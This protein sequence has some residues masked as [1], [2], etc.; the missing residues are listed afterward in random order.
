M[1]KLIK[2]SILKSIVLAFVLSI[3]PGMSHLMAQIDL[4]LIGTWSGIVQQ[5]GFPDYSTVMTIDTLVIG[6]ASGETDY[7]TL[8][9][10]GAN[11]FLSNTDS[12]HVFSE[13]TN[14]GICS[15]GR[16]EIFKLAEDTIMFNWYY[17]GGS[18][19]EASGILTRL[20]TG[21]EDP[22]AVYPNGVQISEIYPNPFT[23]QTSFDLEVDQLENISITVYNSLGSKMQTIYKGEILPGQKHTF[24]IQGSEMP[25]GCYILQIIGSDFQMSKRILLSN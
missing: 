15:D 17:V 16:S 13:T 5:S 8:P 6:Q 23:D 1:K 2:Q 11:I 18:T 10:T 4:T 3:G 9:C 22:G 20:I 24:M 19:V 14:S 7:P 21:I 25:S 12:L